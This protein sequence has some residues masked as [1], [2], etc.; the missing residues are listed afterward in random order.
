MA[1]AHM[2]HRTY[3]WWCCRNAAAWAP[4]GSFRISDRCQHVVSLGT[5]AI[6]RLHNRRHG[7]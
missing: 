1:D 4:E 7:W 5:K 3:G 2:A 6:R